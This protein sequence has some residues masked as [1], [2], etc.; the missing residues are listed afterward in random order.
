MSALGFIETRGRIGAIVASDIALKTS[1]VKLLSISRVS[2]GLIMVAIE[3]EVA[4]V[5]A[6]LNSAKSA[7][8]KVCKKV[9]IS[10]IPNPAE[11]VRQAIYNLT[12]GP[13]I[14]RKRKTEY[15]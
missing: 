15:L 7:A 14:H 8:E 11:E 2:G 6:A 1:N 4:A 10:L 3:G 12:K 9:I 13:G 5:D